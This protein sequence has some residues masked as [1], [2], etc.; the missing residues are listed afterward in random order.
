MV[1]CFMAVEIFPKKRVNLIVG[2]EH[3]IYGVKNFI[4]KMCH[5]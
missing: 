4:T 1:D 3:I 5:P 2:I